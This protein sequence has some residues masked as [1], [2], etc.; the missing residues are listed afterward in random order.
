MFSYGG[1]GRK[2]YATWE[3]GITAAIKGIGKNYLSPDG[4][5]NKYKDASL[6]SIERARIYCASG[7]DSWVGGIISTVNRIGTKSNADANCIR[8]L[9]ADLVEL[10]KLKAIDE[11]KSIKEI[12]KD[13]QN[14]DIE[15]ILILTKAMQT[16]K[17]FLEAEQTELAFWD[18]GY[19]PMHDFTQIFY[20]PYA[21]LVEN[22]E[23]IE[24]TQLRT[25][26]RAKGDILAIENST[27]VEVRKDK[28]MLR[29]ADGSTLILSNVE[30]V[31]GIR[32]GDI[33]DKGT[34][35]AKHTDADPA[36]VQLEDSSGNPVDA[37]KLFISG[38]DLDGDRKVLV[39]AAYS[40]LGRSY[41]WGAKGP[42]SFDCSGFTYHLYKQI[43]IKIPGDTTGQRQTGVKIEGLD[44]LI[45]G[46]LLHFKSSA[47]AS[48]RHVGIFVGYS[49][50]GEPMMIHAGSPATGVNLQK[51]LN[52]W[53]S[54][55]NY[56][57]ATRIL[58]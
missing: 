26:F 36:I 45:A 44:N 27:V 49:D 25:L 2:E 28:I 52:Y 11:E 47:S 43:N 6:C 58:P 12:K 10:A 35:I 50:S 34:V 4:K 53:T 40:L 22:A 7:C 37:R 5:Y 21:Q 42:N 20:N 41:V 32:K 55:G 8:D 54:R 30:V 1:G 3:E 51:N 29:L 13:T 23:I 39:Q 56:L 15:V 9:Q 31:E 57:Y 17:S 48:G 16:G 46:D 33:I 19:D 14:L 24:N 18:M 38:G